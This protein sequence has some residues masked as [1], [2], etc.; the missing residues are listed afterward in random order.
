[1]LWQ[2]NTVYFSVIMCLGV[3]LFPANVWIVPLYMFA[4][5]SGLY[6]VHRLGHKRVWKAWFEA[7]VVGHH[8]QQYP[9]KQFTSGDKYRLNIS[10]RYSL[11][12]WAYV[13]MAVIILILFQ[14]LFRLSVIKLL[15]LQLLTVL[16][17]FAEDTIH[18][19]IHTQPPQSVKH[20]PW[21][22][23]LHDMHHA[24]HS[25]SMKC[26]YA[27]VSLWLDWIYGSLKYDMPQ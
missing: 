10:D 1:M 8:M 13:M 12:T 17:L 27:V 9:A 5:G 26:N 14:A 18:Y 19:W 4:M 3:L 16:V 11:N 21:F 7:H 25:G 6:W 23:Y 2:I 15:S 20:M 22:T 24:H